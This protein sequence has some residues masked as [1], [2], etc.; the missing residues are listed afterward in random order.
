MSFAYL[1][2]FVGILLYF[3]SLLHV[4]RWYGQLW[5]KQGKRI[6]R[7]KYGRAAGTRLSLFRI[8]KSDIFSS[9]QNKNLRPWCRISR[10]YKSNEPKNTQIEFRMGKWRPIYRANSDHRYRRVHPY[11]GIGRSEKSFLDPFLHRIRSCLFRDLP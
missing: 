10:P 8:G 1:V 4:C 6:K 5:V 11:H 2:V 9:S 7:G 3:I